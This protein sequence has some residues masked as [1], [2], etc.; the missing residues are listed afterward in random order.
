MRPLAV[1]IALSVVLSGARMVAAE[2]GA[3][4]AL[5]NIEPQPLKPALQTLSAERKLQVVFLTD[6]VGN[7][8]TAGA[9]GELTTDEALAQVL[10]GTGLTFKYVD[11]RTITIVPVGAS[12]DKENAGPKDPARSEV[13][14]A[15]TRVD[16]S[17]R[18]AQAEERVA[19]KPPVAPRDSGVVEEIV[20]T[21]QKKQERLQDV[22]VPVTAISAQ[23]LTGSNQLRLQDYYTRVPGLT[24]AYDGLRSGLPTL[25]IRG[26]TTSPLDN[27]TVGVVVDDV[28][29]GSSTSIGGGSWVPDIDPSEL[30]RVE[31]LRGPQ[32]A[33][34]GA[35]SMG[36]LLKYVTVS[37]STD[38]FSGRVQ[39]G[40]SDVRNGDGVGYSVRGSANIP[41]SDVFAVR[42]SGFTRRD[43]GYVDV[44][45][46]GTNGINESDT[47]GGRLAALWRPSD[48]FSLKLG[49]LFQKTEADGSS[50]IYPTLG[51]LEQASTRDTGWLERKIQAYDATINATLGS[52]SLVSISGY[53][54]NNVD[55]S[56]D[57]GVFF[58]PS[59]FDEVNES[60]KFTQ[61]V[62]VTVP[63]SER[64]E[65]MIGGFYADENSDLNQAVRTIDPD[66]GARNGSLGTYFNPTTFEEVA[67]FTNLAVQVTDRFDVLFGGRYSHDEKVAETVAISAT[68]TRSSLKR[69]ASESAFTYLVTPRLRLS[70]EVMV[71]ARLASGYR[72]GGINL[73]SVSNA[74]LPPGYGADETRTYEIGLKGELLERRLFVEASVYSID[75]EDIQLALSAP[76]TGEGFIDNGGKARSRGVELSAE[77]RPLAGLSIAGWVAFNEGELVEDFPANT[78]VQGREGDRLPFSARESANLSVSQSFPVSGAFEGELGGTFSYVGK[79][80]GN[81]TGDGV[82]QDYPSYTKLDLRA[83]LSDGAWSIDVFANNV[84]DERGLLS[85]GI[86][87]SFPLAFSAIQ[88]RT[89]GLAIAK[90]F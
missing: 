25:A 34:Y 85:G 46:F 36:G 7:L 17:I 22:P 64:V 73:Q 75:W 16:S 2:D 40:L 60:K 67:G 48:S 77:V 89:I 54:V 19:P 81:F 84:T 43:A 8:R 79:R 45:A 71:Y 52:V 62:R 12:K 83:G 61:E 69:D 31:V 49:A 88:P 35:A 24:V 39:A 51:D 57:A 29:Y 9:H 63:L 37:P 15:E 65:W 26:I 70:P 38:R 72:A 18:L 53:T 56:I 5:T 6:T 33:L 58:G 13:T 42:A 11:A 76:S 59:S 80:V 21:A 82:R 68:G 23:T 10:A 32:G 87:G 86:G 47:R 14:G 44:P 30:D 3:P 50:H 20:V 41:L 78:R 74:S 66:T 4:R 1:T 28:A 27:P 90:Q 55:D